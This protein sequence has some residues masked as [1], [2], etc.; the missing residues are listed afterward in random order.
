LKEPDRYANLFAE[1]GRYES[2]FGS[3]RGPKEIA[4]MSR[5]LEESGFTRNNRHYIGPFMIDI[6]GDKAAALSYFWVANYPDKTTVLATGTYRD[7]L[8]KING[9]MEDRSSCNGGGRGRTSQEVDTQGRAPA[10]RAHRG[11]VPR[12][13]PRWGQPSNP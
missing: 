9:A 3:V 10:M 7:E 1:D 11:G 6:A 12:L 2:F 5:R 4:D 13:D 8:R